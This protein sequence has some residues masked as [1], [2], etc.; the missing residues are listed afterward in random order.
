MCLDNFWAQ[1]SHTN[2]NLKN[3]NTQE[4]STPDVYVARDGGKIAAPCTTCPPHLA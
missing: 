3:E 2:F 4:F 1:K